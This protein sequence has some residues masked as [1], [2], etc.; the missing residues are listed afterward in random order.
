[1]RRELFDRVGWFDSSVFLRRSCDWEWFRR[2]IR[3]GARYEPVGSIL[4]DEFGDQ[5]ADSLR[6]TFT[7]DFDLMRKYATLRAEAGWD[8]SLDSMLHHP[9]DRIPFGPWT[10]SELRL[11]CYI[12]LEY[13]LSTGDLGRATTWATRLSARLGKV[14]FY[15]EELEATGLDDP[16]TMGVYCGMVWGAYRSEPRRL[17]GR[18]APAPLA[19]VGAARVEDRRRALLGA[20]RPPGRAARLAGGEAGRHADTAL[21]PRADAVNTDFLGDDEVGALRLARVGAPR[22]HQS[23]RR[24]VAP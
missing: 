21:R 17:P 13:F 6:N 11:C 4:C 18:E 15:L 9:V 20:G 10:P 5:Q 2:A 1:M 12:A 16:G 24:A 23:P 19:P 14:P 22:P 7:T 3:A 8:L